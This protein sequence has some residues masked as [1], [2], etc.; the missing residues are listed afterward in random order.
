[1][2][3]W[4]KEISELYGFNGFSD[5]GKFVVVDF[6]YRVDDIEGADF[7]LRKAIP[8]HLQE[9]YP[10]DT[11]RKFLKHYPNAGQFWFDFYHMILPFAEKA[12]HLFKE[13]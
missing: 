4:K 9:K 1:M 10:V 3:N 6:N 12:E 7:T 8:P 2:T 13:E 5:G 11:V